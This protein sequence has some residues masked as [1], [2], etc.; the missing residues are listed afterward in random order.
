MLIR[1]YFSVRAN[2]NEENVNTSNIFKVH[3]YL[4]KL[5][6]GNFEWNFWLRFKR[7]KSKEVNKQ[8]SEQM[9]SNAGKYLTAA[10]NVVRVC[11]VNEIDRTA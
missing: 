10:V 4:V 5:F 6:A 3:E 1:I 11:V 7:S 9:W 8:E 2:K